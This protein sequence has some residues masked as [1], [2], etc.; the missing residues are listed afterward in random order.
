MGRENGGVGEGLPSIKIAGGWGGESPLFIK[1]AEASGCV[2]YASSLLSVQYKGDIHN[3]AYLSTTDTT[4][5]SRHSL[6]WIEFAGIGRVC[7]CF[8]FVSPAQ[9]HQHVSLHCSLVKT[10]AEKVSNSNAVRRTVSASGNLI[11]T[12]W[13]IRKWGQFTSS[14]LRQPLLFQFLRYCDILPAERKI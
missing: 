7:C 13:C 3:Y 12:C 11:P 14:L 9:C 5:T 8:I 10:V 4:G 1:T 6:D 2:V